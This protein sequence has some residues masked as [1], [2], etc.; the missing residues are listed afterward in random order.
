MRKHLINKAIKTNLAKMLATENISVEYGKHETAAFDVKNRKLLLPNWSHKSND[1]HDLL[2]GHEVG[3]ALF[4]PLVDKEIYTEIDSERPELVHQYMNV[5]EDARIER[6]IKTQYPGL[7]RSFYNGY[8]TLLEDD[9]FKLEGRNI[10]DF[11][12]VDRINLFFKV[13]NQI[14]VPFND[15]EKPFLGRIEKADSFEDV[16]SIVKDLYKYSKDKAEEKEQEMDDSETSDHRYN[17]DSDSTQPGVPD[18]N[19][20]ES[21]E[22]DN[23]GMDESPDGQNPEP[24]SGTTADDDKNRLDE[25]LES[26]T[27]KAL[28][29]SIKEMVEHSGNQYFNQDHTPEYYYVPEVDFRDFTVPLKEVHHQISLYYYHKEKNTQGYTKFKRD[30]MKIVNYMAKEFELRKNAQQM[31]KASTSKTGVIDVNKLHSYKFNDDLFKRVTSIPGGK[32]HGMVMFLDWSGSMVD[33]ISHVIRQSMVL[34]M[35]CKK[36]GIPFHLYGFT[37]SAMTT[38]TENESGDR[39]V[40]YYKTNKVD[41][42]H[43]DYT[44]QNFRLREYLNSSLNNRMMDNYMLNLFTLAEEYENTYW[45][46][47]PFNDALSSTPLNEAIIVAHDLI[48]KLKSF[49][50]LEKLT[51]IWLTDGDSN[52]QDRRYD[53]EG[54]EKFLYPKT[55]SPRIISNRT[56][57]KQY[58][59]D[60]RRGMTNA[61]LEC[62]SDTTDITNVGFFVVSRGADMRLVKEKIDHTPENEKKIRAIGRTKSAIFTCVKGYKEWYVIKGGKDL[63]TTTESLD[64]ERGAK[65]GRITTAFKKHTKNRTN[66]RVIMNSLVELIA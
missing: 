48:P 18:D 10:A 19:S 41:Y 50:K 43:K 40:I 23:S 57:K 26:E 39:G 1:V 20:D 61:L 63:D 7:K 42:K 25:L 58:V 54:E 52:S 60:N 21:D 51:S 37:D 47:V 28:S 29:D 36:V 64:I 16:M 8:K 45:H 65:K 53:E 34:A 59:A 13:G 2:V 33:S 3:H 14:H 49:Y 9:L 22:L 17:M 44:V 66:E 56:T 55:Y 38:N 27:E 11:N 12:L 31:S 35:F 46:D 6:D 24:S 62:L 30:N 4:T 15:E 32:N 5:V